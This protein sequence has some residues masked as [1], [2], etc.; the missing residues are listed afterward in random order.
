MRII[1]V[2]AIDSIN[3]LL[4]GKLTDGIHAELIRSDSSVLLGIR[5]SWSWLSSDPVEC[6]QSPEAQ[7]TTNVG[8]TITRTL[9]SISRNNSVEFNATDLDCNTIYFP[10][11]RATLS[12]IRQ[13]DDGNDLEIFFGGACSE[14]TISSKH[15]IQVAKIYQ[16]CLVLY[17]FNEIST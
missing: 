15:A 2:G 8:N 9:D 13:L 3:L 14:P 17:R 4:L 1:I 5:V 7:L 6:F 10:K 16:F 11:V 12:G